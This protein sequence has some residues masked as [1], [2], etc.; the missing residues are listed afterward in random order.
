MPTYE[1]KC[2]ECG[3]LF[4]KFQ[5]MTAQPLDTCPQCKGSVKRLIGPG[6]GAIIKGSSSKSEYQP[7]ACSAS[8][9]CDNNMS[10]GCS[11]GAACPHH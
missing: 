3:Y 7:S 11:H 5:S 6:A 1:Y 10:S 2:N 9:Y 4:E 8:S